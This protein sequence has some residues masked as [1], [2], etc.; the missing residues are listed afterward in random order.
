MKNIFILLFIICQINAFGQKDT[1]DIDTIAKKDMK[2]VNGDPRTAY[3]KNDGLIYNQYVGETI[4]GFY[5]ADG[6]RRDTM[7]GGYNKEIYNNPYISSTRFYKQKRENSIAYR[8]KKGKLFTGFIEDT[9][10]ISF[11]PNKIKGY[12]NGRPYYESK[13]I[14]LIFRGNFENGVLQDKGVL[15]GLVPQYGIYNNIVLS[16]CYF[17]NGEIIGVCKHWDLNSISFE[18][19]EGKIRSFDEK[20][21][22]FE[23]KKLL[24]LTEMTY[25]KDNSDYIKYTIFKRNE[26][27]GK[28]KAVNQKLPR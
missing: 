8:Y 12:L 25:V 2:F 14:T 20:Y 16:E 22:Y 1:L 23:F 15:C 9:L 26:K 17:E 10:T 4:A 7:N 3:P 21:D 13:N 18:I 11:T 6:W 24:E 28:I 5:L 27:T 19:Y